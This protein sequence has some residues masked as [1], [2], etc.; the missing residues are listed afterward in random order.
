MSMAEDCRLPDGLPS[1][2]LETN[3]PAPGSPM[4]GGLPRLDGSALCLACGLC[5]RGSLHADVVV[6]VEE[7]GRFGGQ[8]ELKQHTG[9]DYFH[10][11]LPCRYLGEDNRC[12]IYAAGRPA[13]CGAYRCKLLRDYLGGKRALEDCL[14]T[15]REARQGEEKILSISLTPRLLRN[16]PSPTLT[17]SPSPKGRGVSLDPSPK[18]RGQGDGLRLWDFVGEFLAGNFEYHAGAAVDLRA[19]DSQTLQAVSKLAFFLEQNFIY[20]PQ[21]ARLEELAERDGSALCLACGLCC[22]GLLHKKA[23]LEEGEV[24]RFEGVLEVV[25]EDGA[26]Y[27]RLP[28]PQIGEDNACKIYEVGRPLACGRFRCKVLRE[29]LEGER[30]LEEALEV[31]KRASIDDFK[32]NFVS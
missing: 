9:H 19:L 27:F 25:Q 8:F 21:Q 5:C 32:D 28:C 29:Y 16:L 13:T 30:E 7:V 4:A 6:L 10:F 15:V 20:S 12:Q 18:G 17:P 26:A 3:G 1:G 24:A 22:R 2:R 31:V 14:E 11:D 23:V